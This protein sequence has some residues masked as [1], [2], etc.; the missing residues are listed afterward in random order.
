MA[1]GAQSGHIHLHQRNTDGVS[2]LIH[3]DIAITAEHAE[4]INATTK[5]EMDDK[6]RKEYRNRIRHIYSWWMIHYPTYFENGTRVLTEEDKNDQVKFHH[7]NDRDII[8]SGLN[9]ALVMA[10]LRGSH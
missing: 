1:R 8:Y 10:F 3:A 6:T 2:E 4:E 5:K 9:V 7:T